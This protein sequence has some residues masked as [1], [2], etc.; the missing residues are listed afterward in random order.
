VRTLDHGHLSRQAD[1]RAEFAARW[2]PLERDAVAR[3]RDAIAGLLAGCD[4]LAI[5]GGHVLVLANRLRLFEVLALSGDKPVLAWSGG[6]MVCSEDVIA[7]HDHPSWGSG[8]PQWID[9]G[10]GLVEDMTFF[11]HA[12]RRLDLA[13][14]RRQAR[15]ARRNAPARAVVLDDGAILTWRQGHGWSADEGV[16]ELGVDGALAPLAHA[17]TGAA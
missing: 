11:P 4:A 1:I 3:E 13:D 16:H 12:R 6:A 15:L 2:R 8:H 17:R 10:L 5:A 7:F 9:R 14:T